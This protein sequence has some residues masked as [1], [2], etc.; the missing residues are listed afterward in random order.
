M[1]RMETLLL[2]QMGLHD[3]ECRVSDKVNFLDQSMDP[4]AKDKLYQSL[5][6]DGLGQI[7]G[8][9]N[10]VVERLKAKGLS[11]EEAVSQYHA[12]LLFSESFR[13][14]SWLAYAPNMKITYGTVKRD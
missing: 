12:E 10:E 3:V 8:D 4:Q 13:V 14:N 11:E 1:V 6:E 2:S 7:P 9:R 5:I